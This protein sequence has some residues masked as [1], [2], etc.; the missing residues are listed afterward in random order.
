LIRI[1]RTPEHDIVIDEKGKAPGR[2]AYLCRQQ[3][4]WEKGLS[5]DIVG[6]ALKVSIT[7]EVL[8]MLQRYAATLPTM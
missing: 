5:K 6:R 3:R 7:P 8:A 1:V 2:G 4:C